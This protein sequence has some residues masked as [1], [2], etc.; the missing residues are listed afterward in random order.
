LDDPEVELDEEQTP[1]Y[2]KDV[3]TQHSAAHK[4]FQQYKQQLKGCQLK[5]SKE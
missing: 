2:E 1:G 3:S 5:S 4:T